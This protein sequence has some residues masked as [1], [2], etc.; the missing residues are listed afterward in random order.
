M[1]KRKFAY[2]PD[3]VIDLTQPEPSATSSSA[4]RQ[5]PTPGPSR[6]AGPSPRLPPVPQALPP[7]PKPK[8]ARIEGKGARAAGP[9]K[10]GAMFK[11][12]CP[13]NILER[14]ARV[15]SQRFFMIDCKR[16][17]GELCEE[18]KVLGTTGNV[19]TVTVD[20]FPTCD[21]PDAGRG[22]HCKHIL[23]I[24]LKVLHVPQSSGLWYQKALLSSELQSIFKAA[25]LAP[26]AL[27]HDRVRE[28][29]ARATGRP[30]QLGSSSSSSTNRRIPGP[31]D[32]CPICYETMHRVAENKLEFCKECGNALHMECF[33]QWSRSAAVV[34]CVWCR[35][36]CGGNNNRV[37]AFKA[38]IDS[39]YINLGGVAGLSPERDTSSYHRNWRGHRE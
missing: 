37:P 12:M 24:F 4:R 13:K 3:N 14:V 10:R 23:F 25:P 2:D 31:E 17:N 30:D 34:T 21:C 32:D 29:Y 33:Q 22:N 9:E 1:G 8:K 35:A 7:Q 20:K 39:G 36:K 16:E 15:M 26:N 5:V 6:T 11:K 38:R 19:Y 18:F 27:A 28:A